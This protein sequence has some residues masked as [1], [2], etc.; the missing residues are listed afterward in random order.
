MMALTAL[1]GSAEFRWGPMAGV[2]VSTFCWKQDL[3]QTRRSAG[4]TAGLAGELMIPGIGFGIGTGLNYQMNATKVNFGQ[5]E[6]WAS[7]GYGRETVA[8][9]T[10]QIPLNLRFKW[11]RMEG[12]E[13][14]L[15][16]F[17]FGGPVFTFN[18]AGDHSGMLDIPAG[19]VDMQVGGGVELLQH[20]QVSGG[21]Y[22]GV[23]YQIRTK[24]LDNFSARPQGWFINAAWL[25]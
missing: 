16:P 15:A 23:S 19:T 3:V 7:Q 5:R 4:V 17:V 22:W 6:I 8:V 14:Y 10:L 24:L 25:F 12:F 11:T 18:L 9:H 2:N 20:L 1:V 13:Q 21:Y